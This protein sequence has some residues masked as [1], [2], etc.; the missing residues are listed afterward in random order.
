MSKNDLFFETVSKIESFTNIPGGVRLLARTEAGTSLSVEITFCFEDTVRFRLFQQEREQPFPLVQ[1]PEI[2]QS[3]AVIKQPEGVSLKNG[4]LTCQIG[5]S[6]FEWRIIDTD[7]NSC[8]DSNCS[9][10]VWSV[11]LCK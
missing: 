4:R 1:L 2:P 7:G 9:T 3:V 11:V 6:P 8:Y 5:F 10:N